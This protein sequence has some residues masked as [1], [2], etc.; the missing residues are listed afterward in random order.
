MVIQTLLQNNKPLIGWSDVSVKWFNVAIWISCAALEQLKEMFTDTKHELE[1]RTEEL[2]KTGKKL[3]E[4]TDNLCTTT[5]RLQTMTEDRDVQKH[6]VHVH[7]GNEQK[8]H[9][10]ASQVS[11]IVYTSIY[12]IIEMF[13]WETFT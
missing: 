4:T 1:D 7:V 2:E 9:S 3:E 13:R 12:C 6:L 10:Q 11:F 5:G 8:L